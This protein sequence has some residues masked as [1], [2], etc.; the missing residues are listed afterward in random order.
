MKINAFDIQKGDHINDFFQSG[1]VE[2][3][4]KEEEGSTDERNPA[5]ITVRT[6]DSE[7]HMR[8]EIYGKLDSVNIIETMPKGCF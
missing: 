2:D 1:V 5:Y 3:C 8:D 4:W 7:N 6:I